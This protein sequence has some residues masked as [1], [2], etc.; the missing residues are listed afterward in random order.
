[1]DNL[2]KREKYEYIQ[3]EIKNLKD[4][5]VSISIL[6]NPD[7]ER[8]KLDKLLKAYKYSEYK[9]LKDR[10]SSCKNLH[11][12]IEKGYRKSIILSSLIKSAEQEAIADTLNIINNRAN[13]YLELFFTKQPVTVKL[14]SETKLDV[15]VYQ[16]SVESDLMSLSGGEYARVV[17]AFAL[18]LAEIHDIKILMLDESMASLD[19]DTT[20]I[21]VS[22]ISENFNGNVLLIAHQITKG[23]FDQVLD[24]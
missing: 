15:V 11:D 5:I 18:A 3:K 8:E 13:F 4:K 9:S 24:L 20:D 19:A 14:C 12:S 17:L 1:L 22:A 21:V 2:K 10:I 16:D 23:K 6:D 7:I